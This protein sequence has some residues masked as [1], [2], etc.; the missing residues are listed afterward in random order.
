MSN[1]CAYVIGGHLSLKQ[2]LA[3]PLKPFTISKTLR[4]AKTPLEPFV[5]PC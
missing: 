1:R 4:R 3:L 5:H 2:F